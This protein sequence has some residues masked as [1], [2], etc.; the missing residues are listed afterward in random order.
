MA[1][2]DVVVSDILA[3]VAGWNVAA[4]QDVARWARPQEFVVLYAWEI[5]SRFR[6]TFINPRAAASAARYSPAPAARSG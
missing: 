4:Q 2:C 6:E 3:Y 5:C 1:S